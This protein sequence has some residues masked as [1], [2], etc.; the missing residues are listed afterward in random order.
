VEQLHNVNQNLNK[1]SGQSK[2]IEQMAMTQLIG[3]RVTLDRGRFPHTEN[4]MD[5][6]SFHLP[7]DAA[8]VHL[9]I[10]S[11]TGEVVLEKDL[12]KNKSGK[13]NFAWDG[14]K[15]NTLPAKSGNFIFK[16][17]AK[18][19]QGRSIETQTQ[20]QSRVIGVSFEG[21]EPVFLIGDAQHQEKITLRNIIRIETD[22]EQKT[23][24]SFQEEIK[25][26]KM[27][28]F[29]KGVGSN[30]VNPENLDMKGGDKK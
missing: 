5:S 22:G 8:S 21:A 15:S 9:S 19:E 2:P 11:E 10:Q 4:E 27:F 20:L 6:L 3:K 26:S 23:V 7:K 25:P 29:Q 24:K 17:D 30:T 12:G 13:V 14:I 28:T 18:D 1:L 16:A